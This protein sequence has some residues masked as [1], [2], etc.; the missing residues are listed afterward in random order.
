M[1][2]DLEQHTNTLNDYVNNVPDEL[3]KTAQRYINEIKEEIDKYYNLVAEYSEHYK[4][5]ET[6]DLYKVFKK[7]PVPY[8]SA[9]YGFRNGYDLS[10]ILIKF[11]EPEPGFEDTVKLLEE[12]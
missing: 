1:K 6:K 4:E 12:E 10:R 9:V 7:D 2:N 11:V 3:S 8:Q 5:V